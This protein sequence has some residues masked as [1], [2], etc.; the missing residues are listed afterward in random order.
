MIRSDGR[1][2]KTIN[3]LATM[4]PYI[5]TERSD[6]TNLTSIEFPYE[7]VMNYI[8]SH[9]K[10]GN[11]EISILASLIAAYVR[12]IA[13]YPEI[14][15][16]VVGKKV[17]ARKEIWVSF[18][19]LKESWEG[20]GERVETVVKIKFRGDETLEEVVT[21]VNEEI[22]KNRKPGNNNNMDNF[23]NKLFAIPVLP[24]AIV[25]LIKLLDKV[26]ILP[27][28]IINLSPFHTSVFFSN[29][30]SIRANPIFHHIYNFGT[31]SVFI[32]LGLD[33]ADRKKYR[34][35]IATDE[36]ICNGSSY[37]IAMRYLMTQLKNLEKLEIPPAEVKKD[38]K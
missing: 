26:G 21:V 32:S 10:K 13:K 8:N 34:M 27:K 33:I 16:F 25:S 5:M 37:V 3:F 22:E 20:S 2:V 18:V 9:R 7:A 12:T 28:S 29:M 14:N 35:D 6:A 17:Y 31:T 38:I 36:R 4:V 24:S 19:T 23:L 1:R 30:A 11:K 15:R